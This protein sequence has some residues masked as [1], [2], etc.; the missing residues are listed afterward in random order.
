VE[1]AVNA[2]AN[3]FA[4]FF[5]VRPHR[6]VNVAVSVTVCRT[7]LMILKAQQHRVPAESNSPVVRRHIA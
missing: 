2:F 4:P 6:D 7:A 5:K 1:L 3:F